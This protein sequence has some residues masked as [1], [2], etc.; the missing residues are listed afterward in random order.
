MKPATVAAACVA[1]SLLT[2][3]QFPGHTWLQQDSQ[4]YAPILERL[5]DPSVLKNEILAEKPH[6]A[7]TL[8]DETARA[9]RAVMR[10]DFHG[11]LAC[12]QV[13]AGVRHLGAV[14]A[15]AGDLRGGRAGP[16]EDKVPRALCALFIAAICS[17]GAVVAGPSVLTFEYEPT[18]RASRCPWRCAPPD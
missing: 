14:S 4:I 6:V 15:G 13:G 18:P 8:Y 10:L 16:T 9:L 3:F 17:L 7:Y 11:V 12:E 2:Y 1:I 5:S